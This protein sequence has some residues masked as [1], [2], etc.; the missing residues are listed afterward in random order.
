MKRNKYVLLFVII[1]CIASIA[2]IK[3]Y[4]FSPRPVIEDINT[5]RIIRIQYNPNINGI[6][7]ELI[8]V[9]E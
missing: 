3:F 6:M 2:L 7:D 5:S 4:F 1:A 9:K 8:E